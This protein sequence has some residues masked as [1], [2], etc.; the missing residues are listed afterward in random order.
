MT[1]LSTQP[2]EPVDDDWKQHDHQD[3][4]AEAAYYDQVA[5]GQTGAAIEDSKPVMVN[6]ELQQTDHLHLARKHMNDYA[7]R[8]DTDFWGSITDRGIWED[9]AYKQAMMHAAIAQAEAL[10]QIAHA[11]TEINQHGI[12]TFTT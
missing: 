7:N 9:L 1:A 11:L 10:Q 6:G 2:V 3:H 8:I 5:Q 12:A 4:V